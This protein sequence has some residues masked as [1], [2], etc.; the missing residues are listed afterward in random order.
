MEYRKGKVDL[1]FAH[2]QGGGAKNPL[3]QGF[4][5]PKSST[6]QFVLKRVKFGHMVESPADELDCF[7]RFFNIGVVQYKASCPR[8]K[9]SIGRELFGKAN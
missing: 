9:V 7:S 3:R 6:E 8:G 4:S 5:R 2:Q 1:G